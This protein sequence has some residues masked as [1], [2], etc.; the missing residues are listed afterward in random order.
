M[1]IAHVQGIFS[2]EHGGPAYSL[3]NYCRR[4]I[5]AGHRVSVWALEGFPGT[6]PAVRLEPPVEM[7]VFRVDS[8]A[9][10][11]RSTEM[12][13]QLHEAAS[14]DVYHLHGAWLRAMY[15]GAVEAWRRKRPYM[16]E[17]M[18]MYE[19][20]PLRQKWLQKRA[21]RWW[22]QDRVLQNAACLHVNS[23]QEADRVH[24]LGFKRPIAVI[25]VGVD[26]DSIR[27]SE[28]LRPERGLW[29]EVAGHPFV[30]FLSR[31]HEKKGIELLLKAWAPVSRKNPDW[32]LVVGGTGNE[33][34][35]AQCRRMATEL[36]LDRQCLWAGR[37]SEQEKSWAYSQSGLFVL[38]TYSENY[39]NSVAESLAHGTPVITTTETPWS[40]L[41]ERQCGWIVKPATGELTEALDGALE[42]GPAR[43]RELGQNGVEWCRA[44]FSLD[45]VMQDIESVYQWLLGNRTKPGCVV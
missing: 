21:A 3:A 38:P 17:L 10:L 32:F 11:G 16:V 39:G 37:L 42:L 25:P 29:Q 30:L 33:D 41:R 36:G 14:P 35:M 7:H 9:R 22:F 28:S 24:A 1:H 6:S 34:Y 45:R 8:P 31:I 5:N 20:W 44:E 19:P 12:R 4:Q 26:L 27:S 15:Y 13:R 43:L 18:G 40:A 23:A 2:P